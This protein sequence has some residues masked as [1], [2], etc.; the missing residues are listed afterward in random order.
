MVPKV[1]VDKPKS[2]E[3]KRKKNQKPKTE[4]GV[5]DDE[6]FEKTL[7]ELDDDIL[8]QNADILDK[9]IEEALQKNGT[10]DKNK[11]KATP[12]PEKEK[13]RQRRSSSEGKFVGEYFLDLIVIFDDVFKVLHHIK[14]L[15]LSTV[16]Q[17]LIPIKRLLKR[18]DIQLC[19]IRNTKIAVGLNIMVK[20]NYLK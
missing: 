11:S 9:T 6:D 4:I 19:Y 15:N 18:K 3:K 8:L 5:H 20:K 17:G 14:N 1:V 7:L 10:D 2:V 13:K 12:K 16:I